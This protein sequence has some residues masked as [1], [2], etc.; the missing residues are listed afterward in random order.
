VAAKQPK[1]TLLK[2]K[3]RE[4]KENPIKINKIKPIFNKIKIVY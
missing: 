3:T 4:V 2:Q 1:W